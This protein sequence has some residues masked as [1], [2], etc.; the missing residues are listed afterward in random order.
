MFQCSIIFYLIFAP[1]LGHALVDD[2]AMI[3]RMGSSN[4]QKQICIYIHIYL[5]IYK[6]IPFMDLEV[7]NKKQDDGFNVLY[8]QI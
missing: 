4:P 2:P 1:A 6:L 7:G 3:A 8:F 5:Y